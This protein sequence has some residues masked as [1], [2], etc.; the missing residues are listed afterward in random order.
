MHAFLDVGTGDNHKYLRRCKKTCSGMDYLASND[1]CY[2]EFYATQGRLPQI[3][4]A[5][6]NSCGKFLSPL[7]LVKRNSDCRDSWA[8][9]GG[10][11][12]KNS[13]YWQ[14]YAKIFDGVAA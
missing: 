6:A 9:S 12:D 13:K 2:S 8:K 4:D 14:W 3:Q 10:M 1:P 5:I 7:E 11:P